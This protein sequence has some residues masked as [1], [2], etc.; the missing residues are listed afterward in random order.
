MMPQIKLIAGLGNPGNEYVHTRHNAG[1]WFLDELAW[2]WKAHFKEEK[3]F[4]GEVARVA[5]PEGEVWLLKPNTFMNRSGQAVA[6]LAQFYKIKPEEILVVHDELDIP[7]GRIRFKLGGGNGG[8]NGLKDIQ[9]RLGTPNFYRLRL[10]ID[11]PGDRNLVVSYVLNKPSAD[12][13]A[14]IDEAVA[15]SLKN[16]PLILAGEFEEAVRVLHSGK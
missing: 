10:G 12:D 16:L 11:H 9:A 13:R 1:F 2:E 15:K 7:C 3:K 8:H 6:A 4:Y 14:L 5:R